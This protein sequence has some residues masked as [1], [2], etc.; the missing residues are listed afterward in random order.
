MLTSILTISDSQKQP[1][2]QLSYYYK[3]YIL[4]NISKLLDDLYHST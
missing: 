3:Q 1:P 4:L 2:V